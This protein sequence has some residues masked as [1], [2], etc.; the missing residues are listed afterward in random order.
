MMGRVVPIALGVALAL[1]VLVVVRRRSSRDLAEARYAPGPRPLRWTGAPAE[2]PPDAPA[3]V[4]LVDGYTAAGLGLLMNL[5]RTFP[6]FYRNLVILSIAGPGAVPVAGST[7]LEQLRLR[8]LQDLEDYRPF[9]H[10]MN[11]RVRFHACVSLHELG[12]MTRDLR[13]RHPR[14]CFFLARVWRPETRSMDW[15][16]A[17]SIAEEVR[18]RFVRDGVP[19]VEAA[20]PLA[21]AES[22]S[23]MEL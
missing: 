22:L 12:P 8:R 9:A 6:G 20:V 14:A 1:V 11:A 7:D 3:A 15:I 17:P 13:A 16:L 10:R 21:S 19:F 5:H 23:G 2:V 18:R 4:L